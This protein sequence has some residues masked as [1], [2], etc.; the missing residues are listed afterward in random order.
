MTKQK[1]LVLTSG[2]RTSEYMA[3][4]LMD[5]YQDEYEMVRVFAN[6]GCEANETLDFVHA[7]DVEFGFNT[8]WIEAVVGPRGIPTG[9]KIVTYETAKRAGEPFEEVVE[10]YGI[11]NKGYPHCTRELKENP[12]HSYVR[13]LGWKKGEYLTAIGIRADEPRR[14]KRTIS[15]QNKQIRV[16]PLVD[17]F[18]T[19][20]LDVL[21]F[22]SDQTFDLQIPEY[23]GNCKTCFKKS[24]KK[25][26][27]VYRDNWHHFDIFAYLENQ[28]GH[29]GKNMING[30]HSDRPRQFYRGYRSVRDLI[31]SFDL[32]EPLPKDDPE[33]YEGCAASCEAF[34]G[35]EESPAWGAEAECD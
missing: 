1:M 31:A 28:Y 27:Q 30:V 22:W 4:R 5:E 11:P 15:T 8:V 3:K 9:H 19:D 6:T 18:P 25:L 33:A 14:V 26:Q 17:M 34:M 24:D 21:D 35:D 10:K 16:Y 13:S 23:I 29:V 20:K 32:S 2:G 12:I 7:C